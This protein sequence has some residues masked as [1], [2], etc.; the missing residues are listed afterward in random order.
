M[1]KDQTLGDYLKTQGVSRRGFLKGVGA[2]AVATGLVQAKHD[3]QEAAAQS[4]E[5]SGGNVAPHFQARMT[6]RSLSPLLP[7]S[8]DYFD[9][10]I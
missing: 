9:H 1:R 8:N 5:D 4:Q 10:Q 6:T 2:G 3:T 7:Q